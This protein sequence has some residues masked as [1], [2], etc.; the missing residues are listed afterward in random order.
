MEKKLTVKDILNF[1]GKRK[2]ADECPACNYKYKDDSQM[3]PECGSSRPM[4]KS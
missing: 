2:L 3:C 1:K 4:I